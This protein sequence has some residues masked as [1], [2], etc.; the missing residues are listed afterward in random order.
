M[1]RAGWELNPAKL[2]TEPQIQAILESAAAIPWAW[3]LFFLLSNLGLRICEVL[4]LRVSDF[5]YSSGSVRI[6]RRKKRVIQPTV[7]MAANEV[8]R[9]I[10][11]YVKQSN[12]ENNDWLF[13]GEC[14]PCQRSVT[15]V[16]NNNGS[17]TKE[18]R[19]EVLCPGGHLSIRT[20]QKFW[21]KALK[22]AGLKVA[23]RGVHS[24]R[25]YCAT[26][27]YAKTRDLRATQE[28]L[29][30]SSSSVTEKYARVVDM[31]D[32]INL[33]GVTVAGTPWKSTVKHPSN[34]GGSHAG[35]ME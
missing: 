3:V 8:F 30:H 2:I 6:I 11:E 13:P 17:T 35:K 22:K 27:F 26:R 32:K 16:V 10:A 15:I 1:N 18:K 7:L 29:G 28:L 24:A 19:I 9:I 5:D 33:V 31:K 25:H 23:G 21:D 4:H 14:G 20:A 12:L 34:E